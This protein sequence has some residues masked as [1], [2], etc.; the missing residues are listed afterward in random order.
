MTL[1]NKKYRVLEKIGEG[2]FGFI[3][4]GENIRTRE[5]VAIKVESIEKELKLLK[6]ESVIYQYLNNI[7]GIPIVKWFGKDETNY[8]MVLNLL[9]E[10]LESIKN[11]LTFSLTNVLQIG[12][13]VIILLKTIHDKG[14]V[15]RDIKPDNFLLG[16]NSQRKRIYIIDFGLCKS[17]MT[18]DEHNPV[19]KT[20]NLIGS[21]T[22]ASINT[23]NCI[24]LSRRDDMESLGYMLIYFYLGK[25]PWQ[26]LSSENINVIQKLKQDITIHDKLPQI[27][28]N[29]IKYVRC[30]EYEEKPNYFLI[31]DNFKREL[32][33]IKKN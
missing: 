6:N 3:Y 12:I 1:I 21:L 24:E 32:E 20:N 18:N 31:I 7:Q 25:L 26:D 28:V 17:Y 23:H 13:Q 33:I 4:K 8:Y 19:K 22:Y 14:L 11:N 2:S 5:L 30:L 27:L 10:S 15:H 9:G 16:L 29:Y